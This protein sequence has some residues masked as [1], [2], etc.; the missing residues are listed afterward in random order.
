MAID[1]EAPWLCVGVMTRSCIGIHMYSPQREEQTLPAPNGQ[2][3]TTHYITN[4]GTQFVVECQLTLHEFTSLLTTNIVCGAGLGGV[5]CVWLYVY[6]CIA[7]VCLY[8]CI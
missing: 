2:L 3:C 5:V 1:K 4:A 6:V 7:C 8:V